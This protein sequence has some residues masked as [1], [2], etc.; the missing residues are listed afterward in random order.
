MNQFADM[1]E[2]EFSKFYL[3]RV[4]DKDMALLQSL[5]DAED[6][7]LDDTPDEMDWRT[8]SELVPRFIPYLVCSYH[9][10]YFNYL[11]CY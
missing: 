8:K 4:T 7:N 3:S 1:T 6:I 10:K 9:K 2:E 11:S 5:P